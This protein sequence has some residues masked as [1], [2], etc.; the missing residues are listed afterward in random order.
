MTI[1]T[2]IAIFGV[3]MFASVCTVHKSVTSVGMLA[4]WAIAVGLTFFL[5]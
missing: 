5:K 2:G 1:G 3:W 4:S